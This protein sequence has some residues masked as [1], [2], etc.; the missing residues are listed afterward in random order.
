MRDVAVIGVG[1][2]KWG[3]LWD[4][5]LRDLYVEAALKAIDDAGVDKIDALYAGCMSSGL[6]VGQEHI[7]ALV[8]D[9][10]GMAPIPGTRVESACASGG[11]A[12]RCGL[13]DVAS[14]MNDIVL[15]G[16][17]EKM[18]DVDGGG[19]TFALATAAD[20][21]YEV[22]NGVTFPGLYAMMARAHMERHGTT[23]KHLSM[24]S[25]KNH[26]NGAKNENAQYRM[27]LTTDQVEGSV[28]VADPLTI[29]DCSP[30]T[31]GA[32]AAIICPLDMAEKIAKK[33]VIKV[34]GSGHATD[35]MALHQRKDITWLSAVEKAGQDAYKMA[36]A[37]PGD[38]D[39]VEVH[40]CFTIA[41]IMTIEALGFA[42]KGKGGK[43]TEAGETAIGGRIP[44]N[45]SGGLK[46]K[47]HP[48]GATGVAQIVEVVEQLRGESGERQVKGAKRGMTQNMGG[49]G[50]SSVCHILEV[51]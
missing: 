11:L 24:V 30:I 38:I 15:V 32:A 2:I 14:G 51:A 47:G 23:R 41:E 4:K 13:M 26:A 45:T 3:E 10:L 35:M 34:T 50:A 12:F 48:V 16:G 7:G 9:Y 25:V 33:A 27:N 5:S 36:G 20:Q 43:L 6:F 1:M 49:T 17:V 19:A 37:K 29:L 18:T 21:E 39:L 28:M 8:A 40:D 22:Y 46:S 31:D 42:E 44:V